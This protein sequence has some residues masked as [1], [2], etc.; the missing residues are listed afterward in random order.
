[1]KSDGEFVEDIRKL[2]DKEIIYLCREIEALNREVQKLPL[3]AARQ[4]RHINET[5]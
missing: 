2:T 4:E 5:I 1:M 3:F